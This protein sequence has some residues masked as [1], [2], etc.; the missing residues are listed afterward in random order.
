MKSLL[1]LIAMTALIPSYM[2]Q[3]YSQEEEEIQ[4][5]NTAI[6]M[7]SFE[8][9][10][11]VTTTLLDY[12]M[13]T[14][15]YLSQY[16]L[17]NVPQVYC[18]NSDTIKNKIEYMTKAFNFI[19]DYNDYVVVMFEDAYWDKDFV[20]AVWK[21]YVG[22]EDLT[23][24]V[25]SSHGFADM[26]YGIVFMQF[27]NNQEAPYGSPHSFSSIT[28]THELAHL[29]LHDYGYGADVS[30]DW[31]HSIDE[32]LYSVETTYKMFSPVSNQWYEVFERYPV[33][34]DF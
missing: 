4:L 29:I 21:A 32:E 27:K 18:F 5:F 23:K 11:Q 28:M 17:P 12:G 9:D 22:D 34:K 8:C 26:K 10:D 15:I 1:I 13:I 24:V 16:H 31:V 6:V 33:E 30:V 3:G 20:Q 19:M 14:Y 25:S 2:L 7:I